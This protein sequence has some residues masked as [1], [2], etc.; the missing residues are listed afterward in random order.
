MISAPDKMRV[1]PKLVP[2]VIDLDGIL[3]RSDLVLESAFAQLGASPARIVPIVSALLRGRAALRAQLAVDA[4]VDFGALPYDEEIIGLIREA[5]AAG[6]PVYLS[7]SNN[8]FYVRGVAN[9]L[10]VFDGWFASTDSE[11]LDDAAKSRRLLAVFGKG[12]FDFV[13]NARS[14]AAVG[15]NA[16]THREPS[17]QPASGL[18]AWIKLLRVH[19][20]SKNA[21]VFL[22]LLAGHWF[23]FN[24]VGNA[25]GAFF[26]FS[27]AASSIY[28]LNDLVD[29]DADRK[30]RSKK[31]RPLA[32]GTI[33]LERA[34]LAG[35]ALLVIALA[36][37]YAISALFLGVLLG[38]ILLT[39]A[40]TFVLKRKIIVD[41]IALAC[42]YTVRVIGGAAAIAAFP[43]EWI[44]GFSMFLFTSLALIK[45]YVELTGRLDAELPDPANRNY[46][47]SDL[48]IVACLAAASGFNAVTVFAL[49]ISSDTVK[50]MYH[51]PKALWL[52]CPILMYWLA[53][54]LFVAHRRGMND[55][56][57]VFALRDRNSLLALGLIGAIMFGA[58]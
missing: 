24:S 11:Y 25:V 6:R 1:A 21:L 55:D 38:Y 29:L 26:A 45:R 36:V 18:R 2:L 30:H 15:I 7:S 19:Q 20:W 8:E 37:A 42:L 9:H 46:R 27:I 28:I 35:A 31:H 12:G 22:P 34:L 47:K 4:K 3:V 41:V 33:S 57:V 40:Y 39:T 49:Y 16:R 50:R 54:A 17:K 52:A 58:M 43:S 32:A 53:R 48:N 14:I 44:L 23:G 10:G 13:G 51:H 5:R 56:P